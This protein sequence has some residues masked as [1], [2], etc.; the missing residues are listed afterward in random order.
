MKPYD[1]V[2]IGSGLG[3]LGCGYM[4]A[5]E[6][7]KVCIL[8]KNRQ[9]GG[10]LQIFS[11]NKA[12]FDT[13][14]HYIGGLAPGQ[15]LHQ[16]FRYYGIMDKLKLSK[17]DENGFDIIAFGDDDNR[18]PHANGYENFVEQLARFFPEERANLQ[19]YIKNIRRVCENFPLYNL[20]VSD[21][22]F[23]EKTLP[24]FTESASG[25]V[26][27]STSNLLLQNILAG[28]SP[29]YVG[30]QDKTPLYMHALIINSYIESAYRCVDGG[31]Q[32]ARLLTN[33]IKAMGGC[34]RNYANCTRFNF[35]G[36]EISS[37][38]LDTG[39]K[40]EGKRFISNIHPSNTLDMVEGGKLRKA[41]V[42]RIHSLE[43]SESVFIVNVVF[44][45]N[46]IRYNNYNYYYYQKPDVWNGVTMNQNAWGSLFA[47]FMSCSSKTNGYAEGATIM[48][49]MNYEEVKKW[50]ATHSTIPR[51]IQFRGE[52]YEAFKQEKA[53]IVFREVE[54]NF[55]GFRSAVAAY[56]TSTPLTIRDY[57]GTKDGSMYGVARDYKN[58]MNSFIHTKTKIPN[59]YMTG[60]NVHVHGVLGVTIGAILTTGT[61]VGTKK[62]MDKIKA[63]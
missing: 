46:A 15:N 28:T 50:A 29:L 23:L 8:E 38:E 10:S 19:N 39:E 2:I 61:I 53:E 45:K 24:F 14:I 51:N 49:Y 48:V 18:Y 6:G 32:I 31:S 30:E 56:Y 42:S 7:Y 63:A 62:L 59:L 52:D 43:N 20:E 36:D 26:Q 54:K 16:F 33:N 5:K 22:D 4:L 40:I 11:R 17:M 35:S 9:I 47:L 13:G 25:F 57:L 37:V 60:Q 44:K 55:P 27:D 58:F 12:I 1:I 21:S 41:Y 34:I 3:G